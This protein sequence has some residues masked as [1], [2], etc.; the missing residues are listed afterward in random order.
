MWLVYKLIFRI[1]D[2]NLMFKAK[3]TIKIILPNHKIITLGN[4]KEVVEVTVFKSS[5]L[6]GLLFFGLPYLGLGYSKGYWTTNNLKKLLEIGV[7][8]KTSFRRIAILNTFISPYTWFIKF[9]NKNTLIKSRKQISFHYDLGNDFYRLWLD[10][11]MT[12]SSAIFNNY[13]KLELA[14]HNKYRAIAKSADIKKHHTVLEIGCGWG[15]FINF[16]EKNIG[17]TITGITIS[18]EQ[19][20]YTKKNVINKSTVEFKDYRNVKNKFDRIVSIE[21]F[22]AVGT[23]NWKTYFNKLKDNLN[24]NGKVAL[25]IITISEE[26]NKYYLKRKDFIQKYIFPGGMLPTKRAL[27]VL[28]KNNGFT[29]K[30]CNSFGKDYSTTL[31]LWKKKFLYNWY[32]IEKLG[33]DNNFKRLWEYY[34]TYCEVGFKKGSIDVSQFLLERDKL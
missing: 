21:M 29:F 20:N 4:S 10:K 33:F 13:E 30:E 15:G 1:I 6:I 3:D 5:Y 22:E 31:G 24:E 11:T 19:Y 34:L 18:G 26:S 23:N 9:F 2:K 14:Q 8:Y 16:V 12:Y 28:A 32:K 7:K 27:K 25:Q 17:S